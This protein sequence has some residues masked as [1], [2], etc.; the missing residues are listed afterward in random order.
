M[1]FRPRD[2]FKIRLTLVEG[3]HKRKETIYVRKG[4]V[5]LDAIQKKLGRD[6]ELRVD[7]KYGLEVSRAGTLSKSEKE[8][9]HFWING[10]IPWAEDKDAAGN[11]VAG[12]KLY[13]SL[14]HIRVHR[15]MNL[16]LALVSFSCDMAGSVVDP[17]LDYRTEEFRLEKLSDVAGESARY[18]L[19]FPSLM[20]PLPLSQA[21]HPALSADHFRFYLL[22]NMRNFGGWKKRPREPQQPELAEL[23]EINAA[24]AGYGKKPTP[25][26]F[27]MPPLQESISLGIISPIGANDLGYYGAAAGD[28]STG[29]AV[30]KNSSSVSGQAA[31]MAG[32]DGAKNEIEKSF[33]KG[34]PEENGIGRM[35]L[36]A[37]SGEKAEGGN[38]AGSSEVR[39][40]K[41]KGTG[42][43][44]DDAR[45]GTGSAPG[46]ASQHGGH[47]GKKPSKP[48]PLSALKHFRA[49]IFD[50]DGVMVDSEKAHLAAFRQAFAKF[51][52]GISLSYWKR[53]YTG[54]GSRAIVEDLFR[55]NGI[56]ESVPQM[57]A[58]RAEIY[59]KHVEKNGLP[60][61]PGAL[62]A[63][64][65]IRTGG[66]K[67]MVAS[68]GHRSHIDASLKSI[69]VQGMQSVGH[70]DVKNHKPAPDA[71]LMAAEKVGAKPSECIVFEDSLA[72]I[73]AAASAGMVCIALSTTLPAS[74][75][76]GKAAMAVRDFNSP[77]LGKLLSRLLA[78]KK[79]KKKGMRTFGGPPASP[80]K[81]RRGKR[82]RRPVL[83][84]LN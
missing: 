44:Q 8:G 50:L 81:K 14:Y 78:K 74:Q 51:G 6:I 83:I 23:Q 52:I 82:L 12:T 66:A 5:L 29:G 24:R 59:Q 71:F 47:M 37:A 36:G 7:A 45:H 28:G 57:V 62:K 34:R 68:G 75:L 35:L 38:G 55:K 20:Y 79:G 80:A 70:E 1:F 56:R 26:P 13:L 41:E 72:G 58:A 42:K 39:R 16:K 73:Q 33:G 77:R 65:L 27:G 43:K 64:E 21:F 18:N 76:R 17:R 48:V 84:R 4:D 63:I 61:I 3:Q 46:G 9:V 40:E 31:G 25:Q 22:H 19:S 53:N 69:G 49:A 15:D 60:A 32:E 67:A 30:E 10:K 2:T 54:I 11:R